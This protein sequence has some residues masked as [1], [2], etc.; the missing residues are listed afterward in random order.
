M[1]YLITGGAGF[2]GSNLA[3]RLVKRGDT[4]TVIDDLSTGSVENIEALKEYDNFKFIVDTILNREVLDELVK[5]CDLIFHLAA[6]VGVKYIINNPLKSLYVNVG[7]TENIL[8]LAN[9]WK[10]K[11]FLASTSEIYGKNEKMPLSEEH[12]RIL[13]STKITR[14]SYSTG[15]AFDEFLALAYFKE[16]KLPVVIGRFFNT[17][18]PRQTGEYGMVVPTFVKAALL[19]HPITVYGDGNQSRCFTYVADTLDAMLLLTSNDNAYGNI[20]NIGNTEEITIKELAVLIRKMTQ[21]NSKIEYIPFETAFGENFEEM[22]IRK[23]DITKIKNA[24]GF[25]PKVT[26]KEALENVIQFYKK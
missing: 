7:G 23:P 11:V 1:H 25:D 17:I 15:K 9:K 22:I 14:W 26:L 18:G 8:E 6:A 19:D 10:K 4:V 24:V 21:S 12:D 3:E 20:Y 13:G 16:K 5:E 2:I